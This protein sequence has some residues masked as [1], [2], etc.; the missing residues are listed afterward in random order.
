MKKKKKLEGVSE[1][2]ESASEEEKKALVNLVIKLKD[3]DE[4]LDPEEIQTI[5]YSVGKEN[6]YEKNLR[7]WFKLIYQ[8]VFGVENGP[9]IGF[10]VKFFGLK[11]TI[12]LIN[13]KIK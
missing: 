11:E 5:V 2:D 9:R 7:E 1:A 13:E 10:F 6:G 3:I 12:G 4:S 8:V